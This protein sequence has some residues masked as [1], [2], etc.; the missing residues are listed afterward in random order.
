MTK[1]FDYLRTGN[2]RRWSFATLIN[3]HWSP[4]IHT[5]IP[6]H[7]LPLFHTSMPHCLL[8]TL[9]T[10]H[11][12]LHTECTLYTVWYTAGAGVDQSG[13]LISKAADKVAPA[14]TY[15]HT[16]KNLFSHLSFLKKTWYVAVGA[17]FFLST[18]PLNI[19]SLSLLLV[20]LISCFNSC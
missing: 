12:T 2:C 4:L 6:P 9:H 19:C 1:T 18:F 15:S 11:N 20:S 13:R 10:E 5:H 3:P 16:S 7:C 17:L 14:S 8:T